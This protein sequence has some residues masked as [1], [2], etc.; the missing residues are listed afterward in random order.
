MRRPLRVLGDR[1]RAGRSDLRYA[2]TSG[3]DYDG[4]GDAECV[5]GRTKKLHEC[6]PFIWSMCKFSSVTALPTCPFQSARATV[7][8]CLTFVT[9][10]IP[11]LLSVEQPPKVVQ[12]Y[13]MT[14]LNGNAI[15]ASRRRVKE[16]AGPRACNLARMS[17]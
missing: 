6:V 17:E 12:Q 11:A 4:C 5:P 14:R 10:K 1:R 3:K 7:A 2:T 13:P 9:A 8:K 16:Y 15:G